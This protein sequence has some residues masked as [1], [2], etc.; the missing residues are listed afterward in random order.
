[1]NTHTDFV[2]EQVAALVEEYT[3]F[4]RDALSRESHRERVI[5][6]KAICTYTPSFSIKK[7][8]R[9]GRMPSYIIH[10]NGMTELDAAAEQARQSAREAL[11]QRIQRWLD[12][13]ATNDQKLEP[14]NCFDGPKTFG[15]EFDCPRCKAQGWITCHTCS[16]QRLIKCDGGCGGSGQV[17]C[18]KCSGNGEVGCRMCREKGKIPSGEKCRTCNGRRMLI[19]PGCNREKKV[20]CRKC[21]GTGKL[22]CPPCDATGR[23]P[24]SHCNTTGRR[25]TLRV[26]SCGVLETFGVELKGEKSE[27][28]NLLRGFDLHK[29]RELARVRQMSPVVDRNV[30]RREYAVECDITEIKLKGP[31]TA[32]EL[33]GYGSRAEIFD[34]K[35]NIAVLLEPDLKTLKQAVA[36]TPYRLWGAQP[37]LLGATRQSLASKANVEQD[38]AR[39][40]KLRAITP[41]YVQHT[42]ASLSKALEKL[43][44][45]RMGVAILVT[46]LLPT[47]I[48]VASHLA[49]ASAEIGEWVFAGPVVAAVLSWVLLERTARRRMLTLFDAKAAGRAGV[50]LK[51]RHLLWKP[52]GL[53]LA[54]TASLLAAAAFLSLS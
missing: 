26:L 12:G 27:V 39:L 20:R 32:F 9:P 22:N 4:K 38:A 24:C 2:F 33:I 25:H 35:S 54:L 14:F 5:T 42:R 46:A 1:M 34:F 50:V 21:G 49:G 28:V 10:A 41:D 43:L 48:F 3:R 19:C 47:V 53:A 29:L 6:G 37:A 11:P 36:G 51:T 15:H 23:L 18:S 45:A 17:T 13:N 8:E 52:R 31:N 7:D 44:L 16:G 40:L 30:V